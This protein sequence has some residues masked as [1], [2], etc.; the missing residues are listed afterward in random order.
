MEN[1]LTNRSHLTYEQFR[2]M[3]EVLQPH[4]G[5]RLSAE[6]ARQVVAEFQAR[7]GRIV[8][9]RT[10]WKV[11]TGRHIFA[12]APADPAESRDR[13]LPSPRRMAALLKR[14]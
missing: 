2:I 5:Q 1:D 6:L 13:L 14:Y 12:Q 8:S 11:R 10:L 4:V 9:H 7:T 3:R